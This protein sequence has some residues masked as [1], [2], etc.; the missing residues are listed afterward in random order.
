MKTVL[1]N[2]LLLLSLTLPGVA[3]PSVRNGDLDYPNI[4][5]TKQRVREY[6]RGGRYAEEMKRVAAAA[7][8]YLEGNL[9]GVARP[10]LVLDIDETSISNWEIVDKLDFGYVAADWDRWIEAANAPALAGTLELYRWA[11]AH[12]V[13]CFFVTARD[14]GERAATERNLRS[15]GYD[16]WQQLYLLTG[17]RPATSATFKSACRKDIEGKGYHIVVN[18]GDQYSDLEG[19]Y[20]EGQFKLPNPMYFV[21]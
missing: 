5:V 10:A 13:A 14:E 11:R 1:L 2:C 18:M 20:A 4:G 9:A 15:A 19:G 8:T 6:V 7:Q 12:D 3:Q 16:G 17:P 21:P